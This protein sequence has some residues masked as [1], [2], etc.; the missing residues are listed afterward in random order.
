MTGDGSSRLTSPL[1]RCGAT[2]RRIAW[3]LRS[4]A[5]VP[6]ASRPLMPSAVGLNSTMR[7]RVGA[8]AAASPARML[9]DWYRTVRPSA[10]EGEESDGEDLLAAVVSVNG[11]GGVIEK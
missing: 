9:R 1:A 3:R 11:E 7:R 5:V 4:L 2:A 10:T 6:M 8:P